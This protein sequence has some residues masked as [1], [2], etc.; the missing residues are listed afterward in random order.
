MFAEAA[1]W[2]RPVR[3]RG[4]VGGHMALLDVAAAAREAE[5]RRLVFAHL[6]R[7]TL[8]ALDRGASCPFGE[9]GVEG[10]TYVPGA[11]AADNRSRN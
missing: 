2:D 5:V 4:G 8:R 11:P 1:S 3:F 6:G 9:I 10:R 7:P